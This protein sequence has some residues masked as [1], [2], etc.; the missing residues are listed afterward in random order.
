MLLAMLVYQDGIQ[1][2]IRFAGIYGAEVGVGQ[3]AQIAAFAMVQLLGVPF[4]FLF[5]ALGARMGTKRALFLALAVYT[6]AAI[7]RLLHAE[8]H[9][10]LHAGGAR[11]HGAGRRA[12]AQPVAVLAADSRRKTSEYFGFYAV[13]ER[14]AT[15]LGPL[16]FT[17][18]GALTGI[19]RAA[20]LGMIVFFAAGGWCS[21]R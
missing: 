8:R 6:V 3:S 4:A 10:L 1:T 20:V 13:V 21:R 7:A 18:S 9:A 19:S 5:G 12:G 11:G 2:I 16:V 17:L 15:I 14:F